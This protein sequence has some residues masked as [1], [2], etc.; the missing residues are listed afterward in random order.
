MISSR[1]MSFSTRGTHFFSV[2]K[3]SFAWGKAFFTAS[4]TGLVTTTSPSCL[5]WIIN[6]FFGMSV[7]FCISNQY[8]SSVRFW[9]FFRQQATY[10]WLP[11]GPL[12]MAGVTPKHSSP[13]FSQKVRTLLTASC[14]TASSRTTPLSV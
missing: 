5:C 7:M 6:M 13:K 10:S 2:S 1:Y 14:R 11:L 12:I 8:L 9:T 3:V 4:K